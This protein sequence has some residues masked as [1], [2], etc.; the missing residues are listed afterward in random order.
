MIVN[1]T[2]EILSGRENVCMYECMR[3]HSA[4]G[5]KRVKSKLC[6]AARKKGVV[7]KMGRLCWKMQYAGRYCTWAC[8]VPSPG[9]WCYNLDRMYNMN[10]MYCT[11]GKTLPPF[12]IP[13]LIKHAQHL[14]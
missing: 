7:K 14:H 4:S 8:K 12:G 5:W 11:A 13:G 9:K 6:V 3:A 2:T 10:E 1:I